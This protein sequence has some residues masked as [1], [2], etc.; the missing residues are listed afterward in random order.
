MKMLRRENL[1]RFRRLGPK[2]PFEALGSVDAAEVH[3]RT[4][5]TLEMLGDTGS[6]LALESASL[7]RLFFPP[8]ASCM[9]HTFSDFHICQEHQ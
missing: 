6:P 9:V 5:N 7:N 4:A 8:A 3:G 1:K 2:T